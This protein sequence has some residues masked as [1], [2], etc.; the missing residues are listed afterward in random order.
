MRGLSD[1]QKRGGDPRCLLYC[2]ADQL[3]TT[4]TIE[5]L[6]NP[7]EL[8][9]VELSRKAAQ[10]RREKGKKDYRDHLVREEKEKTQQ[11]PVPT[12][13]TAFMNRRR[14][15]RVRLWGKKIEKSL[16]DR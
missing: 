11:A 16:E 10:A 2:R 6:A 7:L 13:D 15:G 9:K 1:R 12:N 5:I 4:T 8:T 14:K 3:S